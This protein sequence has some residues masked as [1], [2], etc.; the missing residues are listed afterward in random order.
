[1]RFIVC[2]LIAFAAIVMTWAMPVDAADSVRFCTGGKT[3]NYF[4]VVGV[5]VRQQLPSITVVETAGSWDNLDRLA[6]GECD[7]AVIQSDAYGEYVKANP[8]AGLDLERTGVLYPEIVHLVANKTLKIKTFGDLPPTTTTLVDA[9]GSGS[10]ITFDAIAAAYG[11]NKPETTRPTLPIGGARA[12]AKLLD[13]SDAGAMI[14]VAGLRSAKMTD[15]DIQAGQQTGGSNLTLLS[16]DADKLVGIKDPKGKPVYTKVVLEP[17]TYKHL[18][19]SGMIFGKTDLTTVAVD[20]IVVTRVQFIDGQ[21]DAYDEFVKAVLKASP[22]IR[23]AVKPKA[24]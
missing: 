22:A 9:K 11:W 8:M 2:L 24:D 6:R 4:G 12:V 17:G 21:S 7:A 14:F 10:A 16:I 5:N 23:N 15:L 1:M 20:A 18:Q 3:G 19:P 13:G